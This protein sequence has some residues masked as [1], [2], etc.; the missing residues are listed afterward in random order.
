MCLVWWTL[1]WNE[2]WFPICTVYSSITISSTF[3][4]RLVF[5]DLDRELAHVPSGLIPD[6][7]PRDGERAAICASVGVVILLDDN[8]VV[9]VFVVDEGAGDVGVDIGADVLA[10][11]LGVTEQ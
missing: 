2:D 7:H 1:A 3:K 9:V 4:T 10:G 6:C 11:A 5:W 8:V